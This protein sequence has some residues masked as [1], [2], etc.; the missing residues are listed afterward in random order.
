MGWLE[1]LLLEHSCVLCGGPT[2]VSTCSSCLAPTPIMN[3]PSPPMLSQ[4]FAAY[5]YDS[6][7]GDLIR[8]SKSNRER[9][10]LKRLCT[11]VSHA[12]GPTLQRQEFDAIVPVPSHWRRQVW[13]GFNTPDLLA[14]ELALQLNCEPLRVLTNCSSFAQKGRDRLARR[15]HAQQRFY[16]AAAIKHTHLLLV[17]DITTTGAT[18]AVCASEL[19]GSGASKVSALTLCAVN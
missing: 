1:S 11:V 2:T 6:P 10:P 15:K 12:L 3:L 14:E 7:A 19:L 18:L 5:P 17:D 8:I 4:I 13:R 16:C 9:A